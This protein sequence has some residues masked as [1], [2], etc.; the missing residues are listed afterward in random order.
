VFFVPLSLS[1][2]KVL[3]KPAHVVEV[4]FNGV[5]PTA[6]SF[7]SKSKHTTLAHFTM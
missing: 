1:L 2:R 7:C 5:H 4:F 3:H 6:T